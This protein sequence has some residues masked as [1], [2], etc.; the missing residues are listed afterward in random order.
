[1][2]FCVLIS[3]P[4]GV[5]NYYIKSATIRLWYGLI[6]GI[7]LQYTMFGNG[8]KLNILTFWIYNFDNITD[9]NYLNK[10]LLDIIHIILATFCTYL[11]LRFYGRKLSP[12]Y[13]LGLTVAHLSYLHVYRMI[14]DYGGWKMDISLIYMMSIC[15]FSAIAF[16]Y[17]DGAFND[18]DLSDKYMKAK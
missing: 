11:F 2:V 16:S 13:I 12:F 15:K 4:I 8:K 7:A 5:F 9:L 14:V 6:T 1:M 3:Y 18:K 17:E 10:K